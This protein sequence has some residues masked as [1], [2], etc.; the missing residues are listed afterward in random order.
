MGFFNKNKSEDRADNT[1]TQDAQIEMNERPRICCIDIKKETV[2]SL[3][4]EGYN[5]YTATLG[6]KIKVP[7][8]NRHDNHYVLLNFDFPINIHE[9]DIFL[10]DLENEN[11]IDYKPEDHVRN[12]HTGKSAVSL[13][14]SYPET[15]FDPRPLNSLILNKRLADIGKRNHMVVTFTTSDYDIEYETVKIT[16]NHVERQGTEKHGIYSFSGYTP[17]S[18]PK[19]GKEMI[20]CNVREDLK[21]LLNKHIDNS[22]YN[23]TF[24]HPT[25]WDSG[26]REPDPRYVPLVKNSS[27]DIVSI[28]DQREGSLN[29]NFPQFEDKSQFLS[30]FLKNIAP[31]ISPDLFPYSTTF[32]WK[33]NKE[34]WIPN[35]AKLIEEKEQVVKAYEEKLN[36]KEQEID[37]NK[38]GYS[39][40]HEMI[41]ETGDNLVNATISFLK[42]LGF[43]NAINAD[44]LKEEGQVLEEDIQIEF[45]EG[46]I[47][48]E[49]KGIGGTS[50]D[51]DCS[52]IS[53][54]KHRR[55][56]ER[57][58]F[59]VFALYIVNHQRYLPPLQRSNPPFNE[60]QIQDAN[61]DDR[62]LLSTWQLFNLYYEIENGIISKEEARNAIIKFGLIE[63][64]PS[65]LVFIDE[66]KEVFKNGRVCIIN[67]TDVELNIGDEILIEKNDQ[68][69]KA[70][71]E[72]IQVDDK[73]VQKCLSGEIGLSLSLPIKK[74]SKL[75]KKTSS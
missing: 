21:N 52:Q 38:K 43:S 44:E 55:C 34:Y 17:L 51:S 20:V 8:K 39:F 53:K 3:K 74:K 65:N 12:S 60:N 36:Q 18:K 64:K 57:N 33:N 45:D 11:Q 49:C 59:D 71:I 66:P 19:S 13:L 35:H 37:R 10:I 9:F 75:W 46:L 47:I 16:E 67:I 41:S 28:C 56:K 31:S 32:D 27:G 61:S 70:V 5:I 7:N 50:T 23:Q 48:I 63:F 22:Y 2:D 14:S 40:L 30:T 68:F 6:D 72:G 73:P 26:K 58:K 62:G 15:I 29:F 1:P 24:H 54:I 42:W 69:S 25:N 4:K